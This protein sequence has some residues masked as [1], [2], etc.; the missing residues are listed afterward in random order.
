MPNRHW[1]DNLIDEYIG[2]LAG[3]PDNDEGRAAA[4]H[5][6]QWIKDK[7]SQHG[8]T[9]A[10]Q[11]DQIMTV[12]YTIQQRLGNAHFA[13]D[14]LRMA[15]EDGDTVIGEA[16][17]QD[18]ER[19]MPQVIL[20][21]RTVNELVYRAS[22]L[23]ISNNWADIACG[24]A[25]L[26]GRS[27][28]ETMK[29]GIFEGKSDFSVLFSI[30][31]KHQ[32]TFSE[33][34]EIELPTLCRAEYVLSAITKLR[35]MALPDTL[36]KKQFITRY[37][38]GAAISC[39]RHLSDLMPLIPGSDRRYPDL[40]HELYVAIAHYFYCPPNVSEKEF[41]ASIQGES[42]IRNKENW[43]NSKAPFGSEALKFSRPD[44]RY[45]VEDEQGRRQKGIKLGQRGVDVLEGFQRPAVP[46]AVI[47]KASQGHQDSR[48]GEMGGK[49]DVAQDA[50]RYP[51]SLRS[52]PQE[53]APQA[54][55][56]SVTEAQRTPDF[57]LVHHNETNPDLTTIQKEPTM[58]EENL[59]HFELVTYSEAFDR[60]VERG[61]KG[62]KREFRVLSTKEPDTVAEKYGVQRDLSISS[63]AIN[64]P[65]WRDLQAQPKKTSRKKTKSSKQAASA[66][67]SPSSTESSMVNVASSLLENTEGDLEFVR[68]LS[69]GID[70]LS[71]EVDVARAERDEA[72][73]ERDRLQDEFQDVRDH[74]NQ[75]VADK[76]AKIVSLQSTVESLQAELT[77]LKNTYQ[78]LEPLLKLVGRAQNQFQH[79]LPEELKAA[80]PEEQPDEPEASPAIESNGHATQAPE[81][82]EEEPKPSKAPAS[83]AKPS[84]RK[85][86]GRAGSTQAKQAAP[87]ATR[88]S[89]KSTKGDRSRNGS[90]ATTASKR[91]QSETSQNADLD[92]A[93]MSALDAIM[94]YNDEPNRAFEEKWAISYPVMKE[95]LTQ[96]GASTQTKIQAVFNARSHEIEQHM[97][98]HNLGKR[99]NRNHQGKRISDVL[100][101]K[102]QR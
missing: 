101:L 61:Y 88:K 3:L 28:T 55:T 25:I 75:Q 79:V 87:K 95:L 90:K 5:C 71:R 21:P 89:T 91:K 11:Y 66:S 76:D 81:V 23:L 35:A 73:A 68:K 14:T 97:K 24:L 38:K 50:A 93:V 15:P 100:T 16:P 4:M 43:T 27:H 82:V 46:S 60:A 34:T 39:D 63:P 51:T 67:L 44:G 52:T 94:K 54:L 99:H 74:L 41:R 48:D 42:D 31:P 9:P 26:L 29:T 59:S 19:Q 58:T 47:G 40:V 78:D 30:A 80:E 92:P 65:T 69:T 36:S 37:S 53:P 6:A 13:L 62:S 96:V 10:Q 22:Q 72:Q 7:W 12:R 33:N 56:S 18:T 20:S 45:V 8:L 86:G 70:F 84:P 1:L 17:Q 77:E 57:G 64:Q 49:R 85:A 32:D 83:K 102:P 2:S 98:K